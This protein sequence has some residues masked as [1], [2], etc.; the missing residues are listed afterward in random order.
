MRHSELTDAGRRQWE[1]QRRRRKKILRRR[2]M[3]AFILLIG[4]LLFIGY[5]LPRVWAWVSPEAGIEEPLSE[6]RGQQIPDSTDSSS[7]E[8]AEDTAPSPSPSP[9]PTPQRASDPS[10]DPD[11]IH[12]LVNRLNPLEP[13]D[14]APA[15]LVAPQVR[16]TTENQLLLRETA[17]EALEE[18]IGAAAE[19]GQVLAMTSGYRSYDA[20]LGLYANRHAAVG[21]E[22]TDELVARPGYS[23]HQTG[24][25]VDVISI[26]NP[27]CIRGDCFA[28]TPEGQWVAENAAD[29]G[30]VIRY[31]DG[32]EEITGYQ[33]E[34]WHLR[35]VGVDTAQ[36]VTAEEI[37]LEEYWEQPDADEYDVAEPNL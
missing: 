20:Q 28:D 10:T 30:F 6:L 23:E 11:S 4:L 27:D 21:T 14:Y 2:R 15:D 32:A 18:L 17:A 25:A 33:F 35:Y 9:E 8:P 34:P 5:S 37:T 24:L 29:H 16:M 13:E 12:V 22:E 7:P 36:D 1:D 26:D 31:L 3:L 19:D